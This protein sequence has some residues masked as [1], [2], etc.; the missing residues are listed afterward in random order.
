MSIKSDN[1]IVI[2]NLLLYNIKKAL[3]KF[4]ILYKVE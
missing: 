1:L 3:L 2:M 4:Y